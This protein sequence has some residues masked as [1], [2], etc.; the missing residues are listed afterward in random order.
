MGIGCLPKDDG[1]KV[2]MW[3]KIMHTHSYKLTHIPNPTT[4]VLTEPQTL[5]N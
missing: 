2:A 1:Q 5:S 3:C 4:L